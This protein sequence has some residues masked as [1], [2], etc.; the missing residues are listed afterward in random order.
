MVNPDIEDSYQQGEMKDSFDEHVVDK[1]HSDGEG[2]KE[3]ND[4]SEES[5]R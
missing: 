2:V 4:D 3:I 1:G 5:P